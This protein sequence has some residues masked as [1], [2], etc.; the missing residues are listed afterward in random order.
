[1]RRR[2]AL[3]W[4]AAMPLLGCSFVPSGGAGG[5][6]DAAVID[7]AGGDGALADDASA[8]DAAEIDAAIDAPV[9]APVDAPIDARACPAP[10]TGCTSFTCAGSSHCY[11]ACNATSWT[12]AESRCASNNLGCLATID[13]AVENQCIHDATQPVFPNL[14]WFGWR[15]DAAGA[16]PAGGWGWACGDSSF[17]AGNWG[18][19]EPN[20][21]GGNEDCGAMSAGGAWIDGACNSSLRYVCELP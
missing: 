2:R 5:D 16:E 11:Y 1:M 14:V 3:G 8:V 12:N 6:G 9:D 15:Q 18:S 4:L 7:G 21:Q 13:D 19:F 17:V 20:N 10:P